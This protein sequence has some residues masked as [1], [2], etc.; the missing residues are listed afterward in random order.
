MAFKDADGYPYNFAACYK[1]PGEQFP[2]VHV[3][4]GKDTDNVF[5][6][7]GRKGSTIKF[8]ISDEQGVPV[9]ASESMTR[10]DMPEVGVCWLSPKPDGSALVPAV[11]L[12]LTVKADGYEDWHYGGADWQTDNGLL[13][14]KPGKTLNLPVRLQRLTKEDS[15]RIFDSA[16]KQL[17]ASDDALKVEAGETLAGLG[18]VDA[19]PVLEKAIA[20]E[21]DETVRATLRMSLRR[22]ENKKTS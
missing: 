6:R 22:L 10:P 11:P 7:L 12:R 16:L 17:T 4:P 2:Y 19:V 5:I 15:Q 3:A 8:D 13:R 18:C 14:L 20:D 9:N 21:R 1:N